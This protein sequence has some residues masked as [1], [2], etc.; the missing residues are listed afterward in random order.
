MKSI[1]DRLES[2][3]AAVGAV[4]RSLSLQAVSPSAF[5]A[6]DEGR[7]GRLGRELHDLW[8]ATLEAR[9]REAT[10]IAHRL[11]DLADEVRMAARD[12]EETDDDVSRRIRRSDLG[13]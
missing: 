3:S 1:A 8:S 4:E 13:I 6:D 11:S 2:V 5:G 9:S 12:Y 10:D 7:P